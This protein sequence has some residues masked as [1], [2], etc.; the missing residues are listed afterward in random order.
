MYNSKHTRPATTQLCKVTFGVWQPHTLHSSQLLCFSCTLCQNS[1]ECFQRAWEQHFLRSNAGSTCTTTFSPLTANYSG[2]KLSS[3]H[4]S[5]LHSRHTQARAWC[6]SVTATSGTEEVWE[7]QWNKGTQRNFFSH[8]VYRYRYRFRHKPKYSG[9]GQGCVKRQ[10]SCW[11]GW[12][13]W[14]YLLTL[15]QAAA[16]R[17]CHTCHQPIVSPP[18]AACCCHLM[19]E[20]RG[21]RDTNRSAG[22][23]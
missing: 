9:K 2:T 19:P 4:S 3:Q 23:H 21:L 16:V 5:D 14:C 15:W 10:L 20:H 12:I 17:N 13:C 8:C 1:A 7:A 18:S 6:I 22:S 11:H